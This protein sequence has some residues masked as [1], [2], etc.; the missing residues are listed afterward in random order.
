MIGSAGSGK[1][2]VATEL[3]RALGCD[4]IE[5][6]AIFHQPGWTHPEPEAFRRQVQA[7]LSAPAWVADGNYSAVRDLVW[8]KADTVICLDFPRPVVMYRLIR[9]SLRRAYRQTELWN[10]NRESF[11]NLFSLNPDRSIIAWS[12]SRHALYRRRYAD[13]TVD[14]QWSGV[15][16][17]ALQSS[18]QVTQ[19]LINAQRFAERGGAT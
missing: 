11:A 16:F 18:T 7:A 10:G 13:A 1:T 5:L 14:P 17:I 19:F 2:T 15:Q 4:H 6:D 8:Q 12:F 3:A 9:R